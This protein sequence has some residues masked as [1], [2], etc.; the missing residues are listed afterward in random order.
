MDRFRRWAKWHYG[1][2]GERRDYSIPTSPDYHLTDA[3]QFR[4]APTLLV[5]NYDELNVGFCVENKK[6]RPPGPLIKFFP[7][8]I[9]QPPG[10]PPLPVLWRPRFLPCSAHVLSPILPTLKGKHSL[11]NV[12]IRFARRIVVWSDIFN[13]TTPTNLTPSSTSTTRL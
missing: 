13:A 7:I 2:A 4:L 9:S 10:A 5:P 1:G 3:T 12:L 6:Q 8:S 11:S